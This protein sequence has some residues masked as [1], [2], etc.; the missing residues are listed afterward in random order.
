MRQ[1]PGGPEADPGRPP[2]RPPKG[3]LRPGRGKAGLGLAEALQPTPPAPPLAAE[4]Q[5]RSPGPLP[6]HHRQAGHPQPGADRGLLSPQPLRGHE[7]ADRHRHGPGLLAHPAHRRRGH[8]QPGRDHPGPDPGAPEKTKGGDHLLHPADHPRP[9]GGG[10]DLR[11]G[12]GHVRRP[13]L[14]G[15]RRGGAFPKPP[16]PL[17][18]GP[19]GV[20]PQAHP[21]GRAEAHPRQRPQPG[22]PA[23]GL[24]FPPPLRPGPGGSAPKRSR[25]WRSGA[26]AIWPP[27]TPWTKGRMPRTGPEPDHGDH[28][29][30]EKPEDALPHPGRGAA[31]RDQLGQGPGRDR[32]GYPPG[33]VSGV[34]GR[35]GLRQDHHRQGRHPAPQTHPG[36]DRLHPPGGRPRGGDRLLPALGPEEDGDQGQAP[37]GLPGPHPPR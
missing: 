25:G 37:D 3:P 17:H 33:R 12:G 2:D 29:G 34:G 20:G 4:A 13:G 36:G 9:G 15:G 6:G 24:P 8:L 22:G 27:A 5:E 30:P 16:P 21:D 26:P 19:A 10:R 23:P 7:A 32:S 11:P 1:D 28:P 35:V 18:Q 14:R 31:S